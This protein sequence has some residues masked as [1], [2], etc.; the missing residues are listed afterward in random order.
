MRLEM[1]NFAIGVSELHRCKK[2]YFFTVFVQ[3]FENG[4]NIKNPVRIV[5][6]K[7]QKKNL[8]NRMKYQ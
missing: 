2:E 1:M 4:K 3:I 7:K 6:N 5:E 8:L